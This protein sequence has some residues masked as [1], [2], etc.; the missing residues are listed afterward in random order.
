VTGYFLCQLAD[1]AEYHRD[2][3]NCAMHV[4]GIIFL[5]LA[6]ILPLTMWPVTLFGVQI[7]IATL[8][9]LPV[10]IYWLVLDAPLGLAIVG[11]AGFLLWTAA[12]VVDHGSVTSTYITTAVLVVI[13]VASQIV[14]HRVFESRQPALVDNPSHLLLGPMFVMAK[15]FIAL[16]FRDDL[17]AA[18]MRPTA[19]HEPSSTSSYPGARQVE[20]PRS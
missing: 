3:R 13:G 7:T 11:A 19:R 16:G 4:F 8:M 10:L 15:L 14:G 12:M 1:Y 9:V 5:F 20:R 17:A 18:I 6:A 2:P